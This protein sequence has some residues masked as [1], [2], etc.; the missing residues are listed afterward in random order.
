MAKFVMWPESL[1]VN[2]LFEPKCPVTR[3][4]PCVD[5][6]DVFGSCHFNHAQFDLQIH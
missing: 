3:E 2:I 1:W 4:C 6:H 5:M